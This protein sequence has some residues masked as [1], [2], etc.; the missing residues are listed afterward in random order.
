M[1]HSV[2][3][4]VTETALSIIDDIFGQD[5]PRDF[6]IRLWDSVTW[7]PAPGCE[8]SFTIAL[9]SPGALRRML[10]SP[11][12]ENFARCYIEGV[13]DLEGDFERTVPL[14]RRLIGMKLSIRQ[15]LRLI[16][17]LIQLP[18]ES[19]RETREAQL[20]GSAHSIE[21]DK[22]AVT[23]HYDVSNE[24]YRLW[25]D[26]RMVYSCAYFA[27]GDD[28][29][30]RAQLRKLDM[31]CRKLRL[32]PGERLLDIGCGWGGLLRHAVEEYGVEG[33]G[34]TLSQPQA[35]EANARFADAGIADRCIAHVVD[36]RELPE[37]ESFD[38]IVSVGMIEHVGSERLDEYLRTVYRLL[39]PAGA[40]LLHG[41]A[42]L[43]GRPVK[44]TKGF[45]RTYVFPDSDLPSMTKL[46]TAA[47]AHDFETRDVES[48]RENYAQTLRHWARRLAAHRSAALGEVDERTYRIWRLYLSAVAH[49]FDRGYI[50]V[51]QTLFVKQSAQGRAGLPLN[52]FD[53]YQETPL[54]A[55]PRVERRA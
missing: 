55:M 45:I 2:S 40:F 43:P 32:R 37:S 51:F 13:F 35:D 9:R 47:E 25:L 21:R 30:D 17:R 36:Y 15:K 38:K 27:E 44:T 53:W 31:L 4:T 3:Q 12:E 19:T 34:I 11:T 42:D 16:W 6:A 33:V 10:L 26:E 8:A 52:R 5:E 46:M 28:D 7:G 50:S 41:I 14:S 48:L 18:A 49:W 39:K 22:Q 24:F 1:I 23:H 29:L 20:L 54:A